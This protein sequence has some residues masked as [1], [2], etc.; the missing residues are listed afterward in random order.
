MLHN[1]S[2]GNPPKKGCLLWLV[3]FSILGLFLFFGMRETIR[4]A[5]QQHN[6]PNTL[7]LYSK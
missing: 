4:W 6:K 1:A 2:L 7:E 5:D 3:C